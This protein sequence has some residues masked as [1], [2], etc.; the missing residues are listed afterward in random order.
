MAYWAR[1]PS[2]LLISRMVPAH[3][4]A[5]S[6]PNVLLVNFLAKAVEDDPSVLTSVTQTGGN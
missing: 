6:L 4:L 5:V 1:L 3:V 2:V